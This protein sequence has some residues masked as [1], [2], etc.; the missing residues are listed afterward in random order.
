MWEVGGARGAPG[1]WLLPTALARPRVGS[2]ARHLPLKSP[3]LKQ[4]TQKAS[5]GCKSISSSAGVMLHD[6]LLPGCRKEKGICSF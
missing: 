5:N 2:E 6:L 4:E 1:V 3:S